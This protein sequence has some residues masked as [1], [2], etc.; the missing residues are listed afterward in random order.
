MINSEN[1]WVILSYSHPRFDKIFL[2]E[3]DALDE[4]V[5]LNSNQTVDDREYPTI[6]GEIVSLHKRYTIK[7]LSDAISEHADDQYERGSESGYDNG[8]DSGY[9]DK[10]PDEFDRGY[11]EGYEAGK[12]SVQEGK[13]G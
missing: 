5:I 1:L 6:V 3:E 8:Y 11:E 12:Q 9:R 10:D 13:E 2:E 7:T 4:I